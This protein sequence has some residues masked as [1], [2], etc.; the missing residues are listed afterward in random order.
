MAKAGNDGRRGI[1]G[2]RVRKG[3]DSCGVRRPVSEV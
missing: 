2:W 3:P 1:D